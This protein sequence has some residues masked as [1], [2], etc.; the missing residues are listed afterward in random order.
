[1]AQRL[2]LFVCF[3]ES[4]PTST[5]TNIINAAGTAIASA[6]CLCTATDVPAA[7]TN[8]APS[9]PAAPHS[10][11]SDTATDCGA[12]EIYYQSLL[13]DSITH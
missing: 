10:A 1:M 11:P 4:Y 7:S 5:T 3:S 6:K 8:V 9:L 2:I 12:H 13:A